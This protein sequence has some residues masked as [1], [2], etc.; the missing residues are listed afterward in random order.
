MNHV[1]S[2][3]RELGRIKMTMNHVDSPYRAVG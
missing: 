1:D 2:P 3:Y